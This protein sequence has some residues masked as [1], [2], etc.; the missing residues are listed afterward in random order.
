VNS[1]FTTA[2]RIAV[3]LLVRGEYA[4]IESMTHGHRLSATELR[5]AVEDYGRHLVLPPEDE[6]THLD[7]VGITGSEPA[8]YHVVVDLWT[9]EEGRSDL[10]L[11]LQLEERYP[12][13]YEVEVLG[14]HVL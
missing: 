9:A 14:I 12:G 10:S 5:R 11:E 8:A 3:D 4:V 6:W 7:V 1:A 13:A 2:V